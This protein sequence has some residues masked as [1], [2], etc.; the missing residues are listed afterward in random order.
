IM[1]SRNKETVFLTRFE[2]KRNNNWVDIF[3][4]DMHFNYL[5]RV[6]DIINVDSCLM[7]VLVVEYDYKYQFNPT[8][9]VEELGHIEEYFRNHL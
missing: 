2:A 7:K 8:I 6:G 5:P 9:R 4:A 1:I 3:D